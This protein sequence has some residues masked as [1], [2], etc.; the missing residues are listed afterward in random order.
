MPFRQRLSGNGVDAVIHIEAYDLRVA[1]PPV[2]QANP[3]NK[4]NNPQLKHWPGSARS[5]PQRLCLLK[6]TKGDKMGITGFEPVF[7]YPKGYFQYTGTAGNPEHIPS[8][9][10][11]RAWGN[12][13]A[14]REHANPFAFKN[15]HRQRCRG[16]LFQQHA[17]IHGDA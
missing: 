12:P 9:C 13:A 17:G 14:K 8:V 1:N 10:L 6:P 5:F 2:K 11:K 7:L 4:Q 3:C 15:G 16:L